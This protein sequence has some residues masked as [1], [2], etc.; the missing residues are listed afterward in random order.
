MKFTCKVYEPMF[1]HNDKRYIRLLLDSETTHAIKDLHSKR[2]YAST[3]PL[4]GN[5]LTVKVPYR[6]NRVMCS[7]RGLKALQ[8]VVKDD[9]LETDV[10]YM[11][12]WTKGN[13]SGHSWKLL[14]V[15]IV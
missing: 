13:F 8:S 7:V 2:G 6:Y 4:V 10:Q 12:V 9:V 15:L 5:T 1:E 14:E 11:G 3:S